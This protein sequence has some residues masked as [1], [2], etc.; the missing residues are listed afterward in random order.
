MRILSY[1]LLLPIYFYQRFISPI[2]PNSCRFTPTCSHYAVQAIKRHGPFVGLILGIWRILRCN[3]WGGSGYDPVPEHTYW[4]RRPKISD[5]VDIHTHHIQS[6]RGEA[7]RSVGPGEIVNGDGKFYSVGIH[8]WYISKDKTVSD[9]EW[10]SLLACIS[11]TNVVA[12]GETGLDKLCDTPFELQQ[13]MFEKHIKLSEE[14]C[15][16]LIIHVVKA[17]SEVIQLHDKYQPRMPWVIH[18]FRGKKELAIEYLKHGFYLS[19]GEHYQDE[20]MKIIPIDR[21]LMETDESNVNIRFL[22]EK[23]AAIRQMSVTEFTAAM[24]ENVKKAFFRH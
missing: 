9:D 17:N 8:P 10:K 19:L 6:G 11:Y 22:Y 15:L 2:L 12:L 14:V 3:P 24:H 4:F 1:I 21:L 18:G 20:T 23:A 5:V 13:M 7:I 16:P